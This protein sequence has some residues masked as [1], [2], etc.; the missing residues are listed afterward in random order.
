[1]EVNVRPGMAQFDLF[2]IENCRNASRNVLEHFSAYIMHSVPHHFRHSRR[3][4]KSH[5]AGNVVEKV[6]SFALG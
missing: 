6:G 1:M 2:E 4:D 3:E 5:I